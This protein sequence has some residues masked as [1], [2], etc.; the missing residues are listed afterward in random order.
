MEENHFNE[1]QG[2]GPLA[3]SILDRKQVS[4]SDCKSMC[5]CLFQ[6]IKK[7]KSFVILQGWRDGDSMPAICF[8]CYDV[9]HF[10]INPK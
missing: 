5:I 4:H 10:D 3:P 8:G 2:P 7:K 9:R 6:G 1:L